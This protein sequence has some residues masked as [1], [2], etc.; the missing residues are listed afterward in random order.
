L[1]QYNRRI[2]LQYEPSSIYGTELFAS[3][4]PNCSTANLQIVKNAF[5][6]KIS[7]PGWKH[8]FYSKKEFHFI[9]IL[10]AITDF[11]P[12]QNVTIQNLTPQI[13]SKQLKIKYKAA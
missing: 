12:M 13:L 1:L 7:H 11:Q 3:I 8:T 2:S 5:V 6:H 4:P 10:N 9:I